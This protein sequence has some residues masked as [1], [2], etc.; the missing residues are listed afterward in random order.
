MKESKINNETPE[1][2]ISAA[3]YSLSSCGFWSR[4][5]GITKTQQQPSIR[6]PERAPIPTLGAWGQSWC[7]THHDSCVHTECLHVS[8]SPAWAGTG[9]NPTSFMPKRWWQL[10]ICVQKRLRAVP[11]WQRWKAMHILRDFLA[12]TEEML[13][14]SHLAHVECQ[15][16]PEVSCGPKLWLLL[17][18][19][20]P[21][22]VYPT[23]WSNSQRYCRVGESSFFYGLIWLNNDFLDINV[24]LFSYFSSTTV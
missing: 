9:R 10:G 2:I 17:L 1:K 7:G 11:C 15:D 14:S 21:W 22:F 24:W 4:L 12:E 8:Q 19:V 3:I 6:F 18:P 13:G 5:E 16:E 23:L 20:A